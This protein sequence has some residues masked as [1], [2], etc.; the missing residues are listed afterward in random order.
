MKMNELKLVYFSPTGT[1][2]RVLMEAARSID[3]KS[4]SFDFSIYKE[5]K[6]VLKFAHNDFAMFGIQVYYG[7]VRD[8]FTEYLENISG[9]VTPAALLATYGCR[10]YEDA[11]LELKDTVEKKGFKVIGAAAFPVEHSLIPSI[12]SRRPTKGDLKE[13]AEYGIELNRK[14]RREETFDGF[15]LH[16]PGNTPYRQYGK[17]A[18]TPRCDSK[19]CS[20]CGAC[21]KVC[22]SGAI[23]AK[24]L[25]K[26]DSK[27]CIGCLKCVRVC[28][29]GARMVSS[30]KERSLEK[31]LKKVCD[32]DKN[33]EI[34][35]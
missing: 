32:S 16:V 21:A 33:P 25:T 5:K 30:I 27:R 17:P 10:E 18:L 3:L 7:R 34:F 12:G 26:T 19:L 20:E 13:A 14:L 29:Q 8:L 4:V 28:K 15:D 23:S 22:P 9:N 24:S 11:L 35:L 31:K 2:R 6:P 1:T